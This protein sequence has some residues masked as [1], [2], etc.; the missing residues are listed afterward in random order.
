MCHQY[1]A[2]KVTAICVQLQLFFVNNLFLGRARFSTYGADTQKCRR[3]PV[4][5]S[6][7]GTRLYDY[8]SDDTTGMMIMRI[9][10]RNFAVI[11]FVVIRE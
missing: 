4:A 11:Y 7:P 2:R 8:R 5:V 3:T 1:F 9:F 6:L 10:F